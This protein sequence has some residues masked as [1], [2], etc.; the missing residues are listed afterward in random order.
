MEC[1]MDWAPAI[2]MD[3]MPPEDYY[4]PTE[5]E[6][7]FNEI[8]IC[9]SALPDMSATEAKEWYDRMVELKIQA[10]T[11][12]ADVKRQKSKVGLTNTDDLEKSLES[13]QEVETQIL[14]LMAKLKAKM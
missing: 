4:Y 14:E 5:P 2:P 1:L 8:A 12:V 3:F 6:G 11:T 10:K 13:A 9:T 7:P